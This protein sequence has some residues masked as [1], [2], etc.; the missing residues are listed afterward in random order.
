M[1]QITDAE[2]QEFQNLRNTQ[3]Y[4]EER[5]LRDPAAFSAAAEEV[6]KLPD[7]QQQEALSKLV[8]Q[9]EDQFEKAEFPEEGPPDEDKLAAMHEELDGATTFEETREVLARHG[10]LD[11]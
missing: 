3:D 5:D 8:A 7:N 10:Q 1:P 2:Y 11:D 9:Q 6:Y 4:P